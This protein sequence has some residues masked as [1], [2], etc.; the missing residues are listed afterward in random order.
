[1]NQIVRSWYI[2][3]IS[4]IFIT[5]LSFFPRFFH[6]QEYCFF[7]LLLLTI[8]LSIYEGKKIWICTPVDFPLLLFLGWILFTVPFAID[9][10]YSLAEWRKLVAQVLV[11]FWALLVLDRSNIPNLPIFVFLIAIISSLSISIYGI[12]YYMSET[13]Q[14]LPESSD[15]GLVFV[16]FWLPSN[17]WWASYVV[18]TLPLTFYGYFSANQTWKKRLFLL[19]LLSLALGLI[20]SGARACW[21]AVLIQFILLFY[22]KTRATRNI[23]SLSSIFTIIFLMVALI[24]LDIS[25]IIT[26]LQERLGF[27]NLGIEIASI[28]PLTGIGFG[29][30]SIKFYTERMG[31]AFDGGHLHNTFLTFV[32]GSGLPSIVFFTWWLGTLIKMSVLVPHNKDIAT[33]EFLTVGRTIALVVIGFMLRN[34]FEH[35]LVGSLS[36]LLW[37]LIAI[38]VSSFH[39]NR[40]N[41]LVENVPSVPRINSS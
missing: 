19:A 26:R 27:W 35:H 23:L 1:M 2:P 30:E 40:T 29:N 14:I 6:I 20:Y 21:F 4:L 11:F 9:P 10:A 33:K 38:G 12:W 37:I 34:L 13:G 41:E 16:P 36:Y 7:F 8:G 5:S 22:W 39:K 18:L 3:S 31:V 25:N 17:T 28:S 24:S 32:V 15:T